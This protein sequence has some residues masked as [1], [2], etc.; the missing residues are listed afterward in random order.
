MNNMTPATSETSA[1]L[2]AALVGFVGRTLLPRTRAQDPVNLPMIRHWVEAMGDTNPIHTDEGA[3]LATGRSGLVAPATMAQAWTMRG[4]AAH[5]RRI[6][7]DLPADSE[8]QRLT[9]LLA[10]VGYTAIVATDSEFEFVRELVVGDHLSVE[11]VI[12]SISAEKVTAL[13]TGRFLRTVRT[14]TNQDGEVVARQRW[15]TLRFR[16]KVREPE[17][18]PRPRPALN[19]DNAWWFD[20]AREH[21]LL[22]QRCADCGTLRHPPG[23]C[24]PHCQS[25]TWD[26]VEASGR[27][28]VY[29]YTVAHHPRHPAF[30][31]PLLIGV[32]ALEE[33]TRLI[34]N[35]LVDAAGAEPDAVGDYVHVDAPVALEWLDLDDELTLPAF[36]VVTEEKH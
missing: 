5:R 6:A 29:S 8:E 1:A 17:L 24:C 4:Y 28:T 9:T 10:S 18:A 15:T 20:A 33:G 12:E 35:I 21:R 36:R 34:A 25:F 27:G 22:V 23:P 3:A 7:G 16:P 19:E 32:I 11:E 2:D 13:G 26:T 31:Y 30:D 14:Y